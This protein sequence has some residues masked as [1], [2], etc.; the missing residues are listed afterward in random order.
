MK[1]HRLKVAR[2]ILLFSLISAG[3]SPLLP[4]DVQSALNKKV[5]LHYQE[6]PVGYILNDISA[7][8]GGKVS[9]STEVFEE[10]ASEK[11][12]LV[13]SDKVPAHQTFTALTALFGLEWE[14]TQEASSDKKSLIPLIQVWKKKGV[15]VSSEVLKKEYVLKSE[16]PTP[17]LDVVVR[18][19]DDVGI[20]VAFAPGAY[21]AFKGTYVTLA[22]PSTPL[23]QL[24]KLL[25]IRAGIR[26]A[27]LPVGDTYLL[28]IDRP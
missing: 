2:G 8:I 20:G 5:S 11:I 14:A 10:V 25:E 7:Q 28:Y 23:E 1:W 6:E 12:T 15:R 21:T 16:G 19:A 4:E 26:V 27:L 13:Y 22:I 17:L 18:L 9:L 24:L 3:V